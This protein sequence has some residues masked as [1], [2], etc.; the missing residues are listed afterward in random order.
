MEI[1]IFKIAVFL[2]LILVYLTVRKLF[3]RFTDFTEN[4]GNSVYN[5]EELKRLKTKIVQLEQQIN[6]EP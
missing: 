2:L 1:N 5:E 6:N 3:K 4:I